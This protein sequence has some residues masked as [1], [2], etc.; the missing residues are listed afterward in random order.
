MADKRTIDVPPE[1]S[2]VRLDSFLAQ[3]LDL[4]RNQIQQWIRAGQVQVDSATAKA[5]YSLSAG[6][7]VDFTPL[8]RQLDEGMEPE[9]G[10]LDIL[11]E[12]ADLVVLNKP[13]EL[14]VHP[15][16]GRPTGTL[17]HRLLLHYPETAEVG[18]RGRP[19]IV[20]RL[21]K[22]T[23]GVLVV[24]RTDRAYQ[25]L[26]SAFAERRV[27][28]L[29]LAMVFGRPKETRGEIELPIGRH[30]SRRKEMTVR[31]G[32]R[33]ARTDYELLSSENGISLLEVDLATGRT[34][35]IRVHLKALGHPLIGDP[36]YGEARW[37]GLAREVRRPLQDFSRPALHAWRLQLAH[38]VS[39]QPLR[40][41]APIPTDLKG[42]WQDVT[43]RELPELPAW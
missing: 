10:D 7:R 35:Q 3:Q 33:P 41:E 37:K 9:A 29:Y 2:G 34:H 17:A 5:S 39:G 24:A 1:A 28:K 16:A 26:T 4:P 27:R 38:P 12:D 18:G 23:T 21:D 13:S 20:H 15:G 30:P 8:V 11:H 25:A 40:F 22:D 42:L 36:I 31:P 6:E 19:G 14:A 43:G 32:G